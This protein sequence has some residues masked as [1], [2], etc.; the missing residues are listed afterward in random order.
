MFKLE[1]NVPLVSMLHAMLHATS[2]IT[3]FNGTSSIIHPELDLQH[4]SLFN[5]LIFLF[6]T[7]EIKLS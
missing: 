4:S 3:L 6:A 7:H 1:N 5:F 2:Y